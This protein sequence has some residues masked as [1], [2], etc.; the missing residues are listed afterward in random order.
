[1]HAAQLLNQLHVRLTA[2]LMSSLLCSC[3]NKYGISKIPFCLEPKVIR[4]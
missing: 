3:V 4:R 2:I 1:M